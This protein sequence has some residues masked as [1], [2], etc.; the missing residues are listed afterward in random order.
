MTTGFTVDITGTTG[1]RSG[2]W[3]EGEEFLILPDGRQRHED[4]ACRVRL[5]AQDGPPREDRPGGGTP[6]A[7]PRPGKRDGAGPGTALPEVTVAEVETRTRPGNPFAAH[8]VLVLHDMDGKTVATVSP[9]VPGVAEP[10]SFRM[11]DDQGAALCR[12]TRTPG[13]IGRRSHWRIDP[14]DGGPPLIGHRG[15]LAGWLGFVLLLPFWLLFFAGSLLVTMVSLGE[16]SELLVW[17]APRRV[18]WRRR[19][20]LPFVG[21]ALDFRYLRSGYR[22]NARLLDSRIAYGQAVLHYFTKVHKD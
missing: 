4:A 18:V 13:R 19:R 22:W 14:A 6:A 16:V 5:C 20:A 10:G 17:G 21:N 3:A 2:E 8:P 7:G 9:E 1:M 12:I 11:V 15:T